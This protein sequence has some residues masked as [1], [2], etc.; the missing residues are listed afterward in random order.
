MFDLLRLSSKINKFIGVLILLICI[1]AVVSPGKSSATEHYSGLLVTFLLGTFSFLSGFI[2]QKKLMVISEEIDF[3]YHRVRI[4]CFSI[5]IFTLL[6]SIIGLAL[7]ISTGTVSYIY[8]LTIPAM[9]LYLVCL[10]TTGVSDPDE[11][12]FKF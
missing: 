2:A 3:D 7:G 9:I 8:I 4:L 1:L 12:E 10:L 6:I 11:D 5:S